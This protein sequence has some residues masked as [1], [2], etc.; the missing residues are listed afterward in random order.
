ME[1]KSPSNLASAVRVVSGRTISAPVRHEGV[2]NALRAAFDPG[3]YAMPD[4][5]ARLLKQIG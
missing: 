5:F 2:G 4:E 1:K 3:T